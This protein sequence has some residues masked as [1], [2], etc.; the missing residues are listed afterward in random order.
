VSER[1]FRRWRD[2]LRDEGPVG[3]RDRR[4][5][6]PSSRRAAAEEILRM[7]G[8][9]EERYRGFTV[10]H[11]HEHLQKRHHVVEGDHQIVLPIIARQPGEARGVPRFREGRLW[12]SI[13][14]TIGRRGR[15]LR[16]AERRGAGRTSPAPC[17]ASRV[18]V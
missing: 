12:C 8:L 3:L 4:I 17:N 9:Y 13:M 14:P 5:G 16:C 2:R 6:K 1:T 10:K 18:T 11:F 7:L 15:F